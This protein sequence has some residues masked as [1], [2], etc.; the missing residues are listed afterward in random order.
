MNDLPLIKVVGM[1]ASGKSTLVKGLRQAGYNARPISQE[2]SY[3]ATLWQQF[4]LTHSLIY[5][6][7]TLPV[8]Q[9]RRP[10]V[11]WTEAEFKAEEQRLAHAVEHA[12]LSIDTTTMTP[13]TVLRI[14]LAFLENRKLARSNTP[15]PPVNATGSAQAAAPAPPAEPLPAPRR[16]SKKRSGRRA[17]HN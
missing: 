7:T 4:G 1:S 3:V 6:H 5:L 17:A 2:H 14:A 9:Q 10:D 12:D 16:R 13:D 8:Q 11:T 15:L